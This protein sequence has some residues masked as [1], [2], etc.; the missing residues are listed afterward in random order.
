MAVGFIPG[1][2]GG[3]LPW[4]EGEPKFGILGLPN[5][6]DTSFYVMKAFRCPK[7]GLIQLYATKRRY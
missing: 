3:A 1:K 6:L 7:C 4:A 2:G 5:T